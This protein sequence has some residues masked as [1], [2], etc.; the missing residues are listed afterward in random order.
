MFDRFSRLVAGIIAAGALIAG[1]CVQPAYA[2]QAAPAAQK[3]P[4]VKDQGEYDL[5]QAANKETDPQ[6]K[7]DLLKQ[8]EQKYPESDFK[9]QRTLAQ[10]QA[11]SQIASKTLA[12]TPTAETMDAGQKAAQALLDN[13]D[14]YFGT[15]MKPANVSEADWTKARSTTELQAHTVLGYVAMNRKDDATAESEYKKVLQGDPNAAQISYWLGSVIARQRKTERIPEA[16]YQ[17][18][19]AAN[20]TGPEALPPAVKSQAANYLD[21]AYVG[22]HGDNTGLDQLKQQAVGSALPPD[23]F[24]IKSVT[25]IQN[26]QEGDKAAFETAHPDIGLWRKLRDALKGPDG[27]NYFNTIKGSG[28]PPEGQAGFSMFK[29]RVVSQPSPKELLVNVDNAGGDATLKLDTALK[30]VDPGT[31]IEFKGVIESYVKDPYMLTFQ[32]PDKASIKGLPANAFGAAAPA[33]K[34]AARRPARRR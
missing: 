17:F 29:G 9:N 20:L 12:G 14:T 18:A 27:D 21:K 25:Q 1:A 33:R 22:Y 16:L 2:F 11:Y 3:A 34:P 32:V 10:A 19:R 4:A 15:S 30:T 24:T 31:A 23:G 5:I 8:W 13:L 7:L 28:V 26:E 6:K